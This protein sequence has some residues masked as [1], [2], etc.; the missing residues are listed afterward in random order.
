VDT[1]HFLMSKV[2]AIGKPFMH[3]MMFC[4]IVKEEVPVTVVSK[5]DSPII[6]LEDK[7][8]HSAIPGRLTACSSVMCG[9][10]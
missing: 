1:P 2:T 9:F 4:N 10:L 8:H 7:P 5:K 3:D 6:P